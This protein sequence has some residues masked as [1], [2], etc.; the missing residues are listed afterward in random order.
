MSLAG[1]TDGCWKCDLS[2]GVGK[3]T[4]FAFVRVTLGGQTWDTLPCWIDD[5]TTLEHA[6]Q[7]ARLIE[8][9]RDLDRSTSSSEQRAMLDDLQ[10]VARTLFPVSY[11]HLKLP[12]TILV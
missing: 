4:V 8:P 10:D 7:S 11:T 9:F 6:S 3:V 5:L 12:T 1:S 2:E